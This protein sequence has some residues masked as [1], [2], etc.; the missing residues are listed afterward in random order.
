M[1]DGSLRPV[2]NVAVGDVLMGPDSTPRRVL[3]LCRGEDDLY[4]VTPV[5]GEP[6]VLNGDHVLSL[7]CTN[8]GKGNFPC[9]KRGGEIEQV[10]V[11]EFLT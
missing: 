1:F 9:Q 3:A 4:R 7:V 6:F 2:E 8:E 11:R 10:A 5:K